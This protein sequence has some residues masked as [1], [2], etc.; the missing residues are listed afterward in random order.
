MERNLRSSAIRGSLVM[1]FQSIE[2]QL[3]EDLPWASVG[4]LVA[5]GVVSLGLWLW[6]TWDLACLQDSTFGRMII[7]ANLL[8]LFIALVPQ[9]VTVELTLLFVAAVAC[10]ADILKSKELFQGCASDAVVTLALLF[11]IMRAMGDTGVPERFISMVLGGAKGP[12]D[13][14]FRMFWSVAA[15]SGLFNNTPIVV[16]MIPVLQSLC[17]RQGVAS[18]SVLMPLSIAAQAGGSLTKM[19]SSINF[20]AA[21]VFKPAGYDIGFFTLTPGCIAIIL[22][23]SIYCSLLGPRVLKAKES[24]DASR[25]ASRHSL[26][27]VALRVCVDGPLIGASV[28]D[29]GI[30]R[31][32]GVDEISKRVRASSLARSV[33]LESIDDGGAD[34][35]ADASDVHSA[36]LEG[37]DLLLVNCTAEGVT[38]LRCVRG[39]ELGNE[40]EVGR[41]GSMRRTRSLCEAA[42]KES[43]V[44]TAVS[45]N[46]WKSQLRCAVV[47]VRGD[48]DTWRESF[49]GYEVQ[50]GDVFLVEA[51]KDMVGSDVWLDH[52][53]VVRVVPDSSPP[54]T[55]QRSDFLRAVFIA[56]GLVLMICI[57][58]LGDKA[59]SM[60]VMAVIFLCGIV[61]VKGLRVQEV[62]SEINGPVLLTIV[63]ALALGRAM[64]V[65]C[66]ANCLAQAMVAATAPLGDTAVRLG[67]YLATIGLGQ[68]LNSAANVAIMGQIAIPIAATM[69]I[70]VG[71]MA[72]IVTYAASACYTAPYGYQ[73]NTLVLK[74]G[75]YTWGDFIAFGGALQMLHMFLTIL[76]VPFC[77]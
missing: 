77:A 46:F 3:K 21:A 48:G 9:G 29:I 19:G 37:G 70:P 35:D 71:Q 10:L 20:V 57:A 25:Q 26:Y 72:L 39:L 32:P 51:F 43:L 68:F 24:E 23:D 62:Y 42:I 59:P 7:V 41:L 44:Q 66:L 17:L 30:H 18:Q 16:M 27:K 8:M 55:G 74:A 49:H 15:L 53:G 52:F 67:I 75:N 56:V 61:L 4:L 38:Q 6:G 13:L 12:R 50:S 60:P 36:V 45:S 65:S 11:P 73:T 33:E 69:N 28:A 58:S 40:E 47:A 31:L 76:I 14:I 1:P 54:R 63:G 5:L 22:M 34:A 2:Q 64:E